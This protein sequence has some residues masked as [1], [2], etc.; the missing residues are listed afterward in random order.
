[1]PFPEYL[2]CNVVT[3]FITEIA[4]WTPCYILNHC[5]DPIIVFIYKNLPFYDVQEQDDITST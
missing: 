1:M 2:G 4:L 3:S 5:D